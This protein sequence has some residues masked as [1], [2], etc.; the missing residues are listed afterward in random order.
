[1]LKAIEDSGNGILWTDDDQIIH[2]DAW[3]HTCEPAQ[4]RTEIEVMTWT[5]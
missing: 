3:K 4:E 2:I 1:M 5:K